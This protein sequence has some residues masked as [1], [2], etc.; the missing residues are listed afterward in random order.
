MPTNEQVLAQELDKV[1]DDYIDRIF[2]LSQDNLVQDGKIDTGTLLKTGNVTKKFLEKEIVYPVDYAEPVEFGRNPGRM[3]PPDALVPWVKRKLGIT[4]EA[5]ARR[6]A[7]SI[8]KAIE[9][10]GIEPTR[11]LRNAVDQ[12]NTEFGVKTK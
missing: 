3:P 5:E 11:F 1:L 2:E 9:Q 4:N 6:I 8:S 12:A 7:F 10:R